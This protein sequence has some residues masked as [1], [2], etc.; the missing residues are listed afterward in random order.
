MEKIKAKKSLGQNFLIDEK[1]LKKIAMVIETNENDLII[2]I[3][4]GMGALTKYLTCKEGNFLGFEIDKRMQTFL[5]KY[6]ANIIYEDFLKYDLSKL[7]D[8][9]HCYVIANIPYYI[10]TPIINHMLLNNFIPD[11]M[12]L[13]VQKEVARRFCAL[14]NTKDYGFFTVFLNLYYDIK[15]LFDVAPSCFNPPP[16]VYSSVVYLEKK[17]SITKIDTHYVQFLKQVFSQKRKLLKNNLKA[18]D[19]VKLE[20]ILKELGYSS[21]V[22]A[23]Q[24]K[25]E[26]FLKIYKAL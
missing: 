19:G 21:L 2:E 4:C 26:D 9:N 20:K 8:Y 24:I 3:G 14:P 23:E 18:Y 16:K 13:L 5:N 10:T 1:I 22:R 11:K 12:V 17:P 25:P 7:K 15:I 6:K